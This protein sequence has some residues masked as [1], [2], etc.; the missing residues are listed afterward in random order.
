MPSGLATWVRSDKNAFVSEH[1]LSYA[2]PM[3]TPT[4][5]T[6]PQRPTPPTAPARPV[7]QPALP[8]R[9]AAPLPPDE[10]REAL[11][12]A[13]LPL[14]REHGLDVSTRQIA[15]SAGVAE[16]TIFRVFPSK[17]ALISAAVAAA[18]DATPVLRRLAAIDVEAALDQRL[19]A[20]VEVLQQRFTDVFQLLGALRMPRPPGDDTVHRLGAHEHDRRSPNAVI[21]AAIAELVE[22]GRDELRCEPHEV[23]QLLRLLTFA[24][25]HPRI[26]DDNTLSAKE[27][28][29]VV[30]NGVRRRD[31][32]ADTGA[33]HDQ[34]SSIE[35]GGCTCC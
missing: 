28:V 33:H 20:A 6:A 27:I 21:V 3:R 10:R 24:G 29:D 7:R 11:I 12:T 35:K 31:P 23:A 22:P 2:D 1:S 15:A 4:G 9:R 17:D 30:L 25:S 32:A 19:V 18:F 13:T 16:G 26:T 34:T 14:I 5:P 8:A